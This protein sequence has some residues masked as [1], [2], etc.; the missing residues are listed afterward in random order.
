MFYKLLCEHSREYAGYTV[1]KGIIEYVEP[2]SSGQITQLELTY[3]AGEVED[4]KRLI[5]A[6]WQRIMT[7]DFT[8]PVAGITLKDILG[9]EQELLN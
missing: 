4:M 5:E 7:L 3:D 6:V 1:T 8:S 9:F 2:N